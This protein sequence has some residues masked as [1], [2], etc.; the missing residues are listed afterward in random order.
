MANL[1]TRASRPAALIATAAAGL[2]MSLPST[3]AADTT[4]PECVEYFSNWRYT[5]VNNDCDTT[6]AV[7]LEYTDGMVSSCRVIEPGAWATFSGYG[8]NGNYVTEMRTCEPASVAAD[9]A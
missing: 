9:G 6:V 2:L 5:H 8:T 1:M 3:A 4:P 7:E